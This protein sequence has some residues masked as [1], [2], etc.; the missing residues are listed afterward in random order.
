MANTR[1]ILERIPMEKPAWKPH[2]KSMTL[3]RLAQHLA[4]LPSW[5]SFNLENDSLDIIAPP[6]QPPYQPPRPPAS[7]Q[8]L[9]EMFDKNV[10]TARA[11]IARATDT[12]AAL[13]AATRR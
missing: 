5:A 1:K 13:D 8:E 11:V 6:G 7:R 3:G 12:D 4:E 2:P 9:L 10:T